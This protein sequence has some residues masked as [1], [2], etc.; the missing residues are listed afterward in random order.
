MSG[1][2]YVV[3]WGALV[4]PV[5]CGLARNVAVADRGRLLLPPFEELEEQQPALACTTPIEAEDE[6]VQIILQM[7]SVDSALVGAFQSQLGQD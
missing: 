4:Q 7:F 6:L 1:A 2:R 3:L 5:S